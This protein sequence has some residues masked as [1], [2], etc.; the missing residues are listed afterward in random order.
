[1]SKVNLEARKERHHKLFEGA[2]HTWLGRIWFYTK[3]LLKW[4]WNRVMPSGPKWSEFMHPLDQW[5]APKRLYTKLATWSLALM[6]LTSIN[7][8]NAAF[9]GGDG[10]GNEYLELGAT[11]ITMTDDSG[12]IIKSMPLE[13][14]ATFDKNRTELVEH[15][16]Q[17]GET[18]SVI[19]YRYGITTNSIKYANSGIGSGDYL[20]I[21]QVLKI[22]PRDGVYITIPSGSSLVALMDKYKGNLEETKSFNEIEEDADLEAGDQLFV[23]GGQPEVVYIAAAN[24]GTSTNT[25]ISSSGGYNA[26]GPAV[27][28][29]TI[30]ANDLGWIRPTIGIITQGYKSGHPAYDVAV[31]SKPD[32]L[33]TMGGTITTAQTG[34]NGGYGNHIW[35]DHGNGYMTHYAH[36]EEYYVQVGD[37]VSQGEVIGKMGNTGRVYGATGIH[38]HFEISYQGTKINPSFMGVW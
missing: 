8:S 12:Y 7:V 33:A 37:V 17:E 27:D 32:I 24:S 20:K 4:I 23:V 14:E 31:R 5:P 30:P 6:V 29:Y 1:M 28:Q 18:L 10:V 2:Y 13:G 19:A 3:R 38:L 34:W 36:L 35:I 26:S 9:G 16:V 22:P 11:E 15:E 21:G 25:Y